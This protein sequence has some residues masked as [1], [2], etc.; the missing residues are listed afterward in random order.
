MKGVLEMRRV[1]LLNQSGEPLT[2]IHWTRALNLY[3]KGRAQ[4]VEYF[5][6]AEVHSGHSRETGERRS[7]QIPSVMVLMKYIVLTKGREVA[8]SK[9]NLMLRDEHECQYCGKH[10]RADTAT[11]DHVV[12]V[13]RGGRNTWKN[14]VLS[15][16]PCNNTKD[17][18]T[19]QEAGMQLKRKPWTPSRVLLLQQTALQENVDAWKPYLKLA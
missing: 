15:C 8:L 7:F 5:E 19:P 2:F 16:K 9:R 6:N 17:N 13:S 10:L 18:R 1:L 12:P 14:T 4:P 11:I 3:F